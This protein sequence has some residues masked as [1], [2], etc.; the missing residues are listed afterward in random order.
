M[1]TTFPGSPST[2]AGGFIVMDADGKVV[3]RTVAF[4]YN[5]DTLTRT[6]APRA[7]KVESGDRLEALRLIGPPVETIKLEIDLDATDR[8]ASP[9]RNPQTVSDG[10]S[11]ELADLETIASPRA[12]DVDAANRM[13]Q[14]G[15]LEVLPLPSPLVLLVLGANRILPVRITELSMVEEAFD[16][17]LNPIRARVSVG[18]RVLSVDDLAFGTK[19]AELFMAMMRRR[20]KLATR[21]PANL[22][23]LGLDRVP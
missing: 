4:Q 7:A 20:E 9:E 11:P 21:K 5:P 2:L 14:S 1:T 18:L 12:D 23:S 8:L 19:G 16:P 22:Q 13:A 10:I 17:R 3:L 15:T 6:V